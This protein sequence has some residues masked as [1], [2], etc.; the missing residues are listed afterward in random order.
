MAFS[1]KHLKVIE[2]FQFSPDLGADNMIYFETEGKAALSAF[3]PVSLEYVL[4]YPA[5][6]CGALP[7]P[8][9][10]FRNRQL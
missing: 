8:L 7:S 2:G 3:M 10:A 9:E 6:F 1:T 5:P 4:A